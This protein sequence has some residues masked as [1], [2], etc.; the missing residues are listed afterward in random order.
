MN[1]GWDRVVVR[2]VVGSVIDRQKSR[3]N[4]QSELKM[5]GGPRWTRNVLDLLETDAKV[6]LLFSGSGGG[7]EN[8][9][10]TVSEKTGDDQERSCS[11]RPHGERVEGTAGML[12]RDIAV[13]PYT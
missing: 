2:V 8:G 7:F 10:L 13:S 5:A 9:L 12:C 4:S 3:S 6:S 1:A 11:I